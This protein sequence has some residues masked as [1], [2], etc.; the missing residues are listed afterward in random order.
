M[1]NSCKP[2]IQLMISPH[3]LATPSNNSHKRLCWVSGLWQYAMERCFTEKG[4]GLEGWLC[5]CCGGGGGD[6]CYNV[7]WGPYEGLPL[8]EY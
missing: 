4:S 3:H 8:E 5:V 2:K 7:V 6:W 1:E